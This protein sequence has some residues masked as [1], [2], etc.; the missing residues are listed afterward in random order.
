[1]KS[2]RIIYHL[3]RADFFERVR[4]YSFL[5]ML[6]L[7]VFLGYQTAIGNMALELGQ[8]R[9]E[10]NSA[11]VG[12]MMSLIGTFFIGWFGFYLVKGSVARDRETGVG[13]IMATTP[14]TRPLYLLGKWL[15]NFAVLMAMV[16]VLAL[17]G[18]VIQLL[19]GEN[20]QIQLFAFL[21][22]F[23]FIVMPLM[24]LVAALAVLFESISFLQGGFGNIV[25]FFAFI[26]FVPLF[27]ENDTLS[28]YPA[29]EPMGLG[30]LSGEMGR[31][32]S[33]IHPDYDGSFTLGGGIV[34]QATTTFV[35]NG[36]AWTP[37]YIFARFSLIV[38]AVG[39]IF[40][41]ALFFD[42]FDP[43]RSKPRK[44][45]SASSSEPTPAST[46]QALPVPHLTPLN[47]SANRFSFF[48]V[49]IA[50]LKLLLK[51]QRWW[52]YVVALG[53]I[54]ACVANPS[55]VVREIVLPIAW[56]WPIL[57]WSSIGNREIH[58]NVQQL[59]FSSASPLWRQVPSQWLAGLIVTLLVSIGA[60]FRFIM[61]GDT[62]GLLA[63]LS[64]AIFIPSLALA[65]GV[66]SG[67]SKLF[68]ILYMVIWYIGPLNKVPE[69]DYIGS[70]SNG[71]PE[72]FIPFSIA[73]IAFAI[74]GRARQLRN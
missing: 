42:R 16:G 49:L 57:I 69:L 51:G 47:K 29:F 54:V 17:A 18:I 12:A 1:M 6:G 40:L 8:Y 7:V 53:I 32:V 37:E 34:E 26:M 43:S 4:R 52:W 64:G 25:Y 55:T 50:E 11:W 61:D 72:F 41:A 44:A 22:P 62:V 15:S 70:H 27:M 68:E 73:L 46:S 20:T 10:F 74:F 30:L 71:R 35:W 67:T 14:L 36:I 23:V 9:G 5:V 24:A 63:L 31:A 66:W 45:R 39:L 58:N 65:S 21:D 56:V 13:Q 48:T 3:A 38:L 60:I 19:Q 59:T 2:A 33:A 28:Q